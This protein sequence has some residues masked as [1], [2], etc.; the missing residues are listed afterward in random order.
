MGLL[1]AMFDCQNEAINLW[2]MNGEYILFRCKRCKKEKIYCVR[3][4]RDLTNDEKGREFM[5]KMMSSP[6][7]SLAC[8]IHSEFV[9][10]ERDYP[11][12]LNKREEL[13]K[14][15]QKKYNL[16]S[17]NRPA[18]PVIMLEKGLWIEKRNMDQG[19]VE[20]KIKPESKPKKEKDKKMTGRIQRPVRGE[21]EFFTNEVQPVK[22]KFEESESNDLESMNL[23]S[24]KELESRYVQE[25]KYE[26]AAEVR[27]RIN[28]L[29]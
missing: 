13:F 29:K 20:E 24:L 15:I 27:D 5:Y 7:F 8:Q 21:S 18:D 4:N 25:E 23:E 19:E 9:K 14:E 22:Y 28:K 1:C 26:K 6:D 16:P 10:V 2:G 11:L 17:S 3:E 12:N